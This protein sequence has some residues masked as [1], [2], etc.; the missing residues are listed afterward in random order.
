MNI[1]LFVFGAIAVVIVGFF[2]LLVGVSLV[3]KQPVKEFVPVGPTITVNPSPYYLAVT[4]AAT[5]LGF[6]A[7]GVFVP[8]RPQKTYRFHVA[9][10][11]SPEHDTLL[12]IAAGKV[13]GLPL[14][15]T[16]L[17]SC[18]GNGQTVETSDEPGLPDQSG[19]TQHEFLLN[20]DLNELW[21]LHRNRLTL[22]PE[23][24]REFTEANALEAYETT[25]MVRVSQL[26]K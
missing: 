13:A 9:L 3:E 23:V 26:I 10:F 11:V 7:A 6:T 25:Q 18:L 1:E 24:R 19:L 15:K 2:L 22:L 17:M 14:K 21:T 12:K 8:N 16:T 4:D 20:A 5:R